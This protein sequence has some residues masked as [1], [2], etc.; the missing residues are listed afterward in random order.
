M[1]YFQK[2]LIQNFHILKL[3]LTDEASKPLDIEDK[4]NI[5]LVIN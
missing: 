3:W 5:I 2:L 1:L 4:V